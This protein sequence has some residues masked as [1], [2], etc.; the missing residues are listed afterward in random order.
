MSTLFTIFVLKISFKCLSLSPTPCLKLS[1][2]HFLPSDGGM[3][4]SQDDSIV[5]TKQCRHSLAIMPIPGNL[6]S[7]SP[8]LLQPA[9]SVLDFSN[10]AGKKNFNL[11]IFSLS[12]SV[13]FGL[14]CSTYRQSA[15]QEQS[16]DDFWDTEKKMDSV[17]ICT[18]MFNLLRC[19]FCFVAHNG[20]E[21][22]GFLRSSSHSVCVAFYCRSLCLSLCDS[23]EIQLQAQDWVKTFITPAVCELWPSQSFSGVSVT[24]EGSSTEGVGHTRPSTSAWLNHLRTEGLECSAS[25]QRCC[26][27][28]LSSLSVTSK[29]SAVKSPYCTHSFSLIYKRIL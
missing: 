6:S 9:T 1:P 24:A 13:C 19:K 4:Q 16:L 10:P 20:T 14:F 29:S 21:E 23:D 28:G 3:G 11:T 7:S 22:I 25:T 12:V 27:N 2:S 17:Q 8:D 18:S 26:A 15:C 5:G